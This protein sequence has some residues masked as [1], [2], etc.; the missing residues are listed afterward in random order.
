MVFVDGTNLLFRLQAE[1]LIVPRLECIFSQFEQV[2]RGSEIVRIYLYTVKEQVDKAL[3]VHGPTCFEGIRVVLGDGIPTSGGIKEKAVDALLVADLI[4]HAA[5]RNCDGAVLISHDTDFVYAIKRV[6]DFGCR[7]AVGGICQE[8]SDRLKI[9]ADRNF[10][11]TADAMVARNVAK[12]M[13]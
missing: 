1:K 12:R 9:A 6:E 5:S 10:T 7:S 2:H 13:P 3:Q 4:Y 8:L 11:V